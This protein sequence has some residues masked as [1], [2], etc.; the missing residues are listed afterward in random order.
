MPKQLVMDHTGHS[1]HVFDKA[2]VVSFKEA[3]AR[4]MELTG[5]G[6]TAAVRAPDGRSDLV[7]TFDADAEETLFIP[8]LQG[9]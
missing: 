1:E 7:R 8:R 4:F 6:F 3:E 9:G 2:D 5:K